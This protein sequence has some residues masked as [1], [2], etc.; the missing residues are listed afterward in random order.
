MASP[1]ADARLTSCG[2]VADSTPARDAQQTVVEQSVYL[3]QTLMETMKKWEA[4]LQ[5]LEAE[6]T[7]RRTPRQC[8]LTWRQRE[9]LTLLYNGM[10]RSA[11]AKQLTI[12][13]DTVQTHIRDA[14][15]RL[16]TSGGMRAAIKAYQ[17]GLLLEE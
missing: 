11:I 3:V 5:R 2:L 15:R 13:K 4:R 6:E 12:Q 9:V 10:Q 1:T 8:K 17:L 7:A 16:G 14:N